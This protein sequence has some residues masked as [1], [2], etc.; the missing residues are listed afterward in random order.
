MYISALCISLLLMHHAAQIHA[1]PAP[2][3]ALAPTTGLQFTGPPLS[4]LQ[5]TL[6]ASHPFNLSIPEPYSHTSGSGASLKISW[7]WP[8]PDTDLTLFLDSFPN[9]PVDKTN[10]LN[11]LAII[12][13][14][15]TSHLK[16][17]G[18]GWLDPADDPIDEPVKNVNSDADW[19]VKFESNPWR[20]P[21]QRRQHLTYTTVAFVVDIWTQLINGVMGAC[22]T[23]GGIQ[24]S[25]W[26][27]V[28]NMAATPPGYP[29]RS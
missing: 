11:T 26:G 15:M 18:D 29:R 2:A 20:G 14:R 9:T 22:H 24:D 27:L 13:Q 23:F 16:S 1:A 5:P 12:K 3:P 17:R 28:G 10:L 4:L 8:V 19:H 6:N 25:E 7:V 21:G